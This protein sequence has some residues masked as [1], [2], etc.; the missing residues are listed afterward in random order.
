[1]VLLPITIGRALLVA[2][3]LGVIPAG[4]GDEATSG[5]PVERAMTAV[6]DPWTRVI[7][8]PGSNDCPDNMYWDEASGAIVLPPTTIAATVPVGGTFIVGE[9][10]PLTLSDEPDSNCWDDA[11]SCG[12]AAAD[13]IVIWPGCVGDSVT[14]TAL[15]AC[16]STL[17]MPTCNVVPGGLVTNTTVVVDEAS[18]LAADDTKTSVKLVV[19]NW[20][21]EGVVGSKATGVVGIDEGNWKVLGDS[22][23]EVWA[24][25]EAACEE[26]TAEGTDPL[27]F[28]PA[29]S[30]DGSSL[31]ADGRATWVVWDWRVSVLVNGCVVACWT[32]TGVDEG[33]WTTLGSVVDG[34]TSEPKD[35][36]DACIDP[37]GLA[38]T[39][40]TST[41]I[42]PVEVSAEKDALECSD[43]IVP[44]GVAAAWIALLGPEVVMVVV[45]NK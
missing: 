22:G 17:D 11:V 39:G 6:D 19:T 38:A 24:G 33:G 23:A 7:E 4:T 27:A 13:E 42:C 28:S 35:P 10:P 44:S 21:V 43:E 14:T 12:R 30:P 16:D 40:S 3:T 2:A 1:M 31:G 15:E 37:V 34:L 20:A 41:V 18:P 9:S 29:L 8:E 5:W 45:A 25:G 36:L 26:M 32:E